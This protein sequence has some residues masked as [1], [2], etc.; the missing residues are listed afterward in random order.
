MRAASS[1]A[2]LLALLALLAAAASPAAAAFYE[3]EAP[4]WAAWRANVKA[5]RVPGGKDGAT[6]GDAL[7][8]LLDYK[9]D[10]PLEFMRRSQVRARVFCLS[11][12][13]AFL[14][15]EC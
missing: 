11:R 6:V 7:G 8:P 5:M 12:G 2:A 3:G 15:T 9:F 10:L 13:I 4:E 14:L 1:A